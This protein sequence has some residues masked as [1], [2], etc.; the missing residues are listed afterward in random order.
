M[1]STA[2]QAQADALGEVS[3]ATEY[4]RTV[5]AEAE[6]R[7]RAAVRTALAV[8]VP[9]P[10]IASAARITRGRVYQIRDGRR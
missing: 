1:S 3:S 2:D 6:E 10:A 4:R 7:F 5:T 8:G 9:V